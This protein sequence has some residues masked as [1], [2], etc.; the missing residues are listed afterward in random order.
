MDQPL[1]DQSQQYINLTN[2]LI[3]LGVSTEQIYNMSSKPLN[4][5]TLNNLKT[6]STNIVKH[7]TCNSHKYRKGYCV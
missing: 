7:N 1:A 2:H 5:G 4:V 3:S 6:P